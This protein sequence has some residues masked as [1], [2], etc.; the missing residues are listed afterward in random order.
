MAVTN[1]EWLQRLN[2]S[3]VEMSRQI[4]EA[5]VVLRREIHDLRVELLTET[6]DLRKDFESFKSRINALT[7]VFGA[8]FIVIHGFSISSVYSAGKMR[9]RCVNTSIRFATLTSTWVN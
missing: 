5:H 4:H 3:V 9:P 7:A 6:K 8:A 1:E 2:N